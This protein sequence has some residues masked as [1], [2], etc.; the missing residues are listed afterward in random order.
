M[1]Y[2]HT[3]TPLRTP[4]QNI[5]LNVSPMTQTDIPHRQ[6]HR[7]THEV[8]GSFR[9]APSNTQTHTY[10]RI[11]ANTH[12]YT[13]THV[14]LCRHVHLLHHLECILK[15]MVV[16]YIKAV[17]AVVHVSL[18]S[19]HSAVLGTQLGK[20]CYYSITHSSAPSHG[21]HVP[22]ALERLHALPLQ[23]SLTGL[24]KDGPPTPTPPS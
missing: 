5:T 19:C 4:D 22:P 23:V 7:T 17:Y 24:D 8:R 12:T 14:R 13:H 18:S 21:S 15:Q 6:S 20:L 11:H 16:M 9:L 1:V 3:P 10:I 2:K